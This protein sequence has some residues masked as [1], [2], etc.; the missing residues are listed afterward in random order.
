MQAIQ[1]L[2]HCCPFQTRHYEDCVGESSIYPNTPVEAN[3]NREFDFTSE[4]L[5]ELALR[6]KQF[7]TKPNREV[8]DKTT[9]QFSKECFT[10]VPGLLAEGTNA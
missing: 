10:S 9:L 3:V 8:F 1:V 4:L 7:A 6:L 2:L 5:E